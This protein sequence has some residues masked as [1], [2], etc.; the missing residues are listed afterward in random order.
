MSMGMTGSQQQYTLFKSCSQV[1]HMKVCTSALQD[2][3]DFCANSSS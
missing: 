3:H 1:R 2:C